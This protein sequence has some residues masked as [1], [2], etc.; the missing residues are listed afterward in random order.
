MVQTM[1]SDAVSS[2]DIELPPD[3]QVLEKQDRS[4]IEL[5]ETWKKLKAEYD[6]RCGLVVD[7]MT[8]YKA[9]NGSEGCRGYLAGVLTSIAFE[10]DDAYLQ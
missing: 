2:P 6:L 8:I 10:R 7:W 9:T 3:C 4:N 5:P 1:S